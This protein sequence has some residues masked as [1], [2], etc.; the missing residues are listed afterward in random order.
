MGGQSG[1]G[2]YCCEGSM[3]MVSVT[4]NASLKPVSSVWGLG[5][6]NTRT[7]DAERRTQNKNKTCLTAEYAERRR[8]IPGSWILDLGTLLTA[9][10]LVF[11]AGCSGQQ[12]RER[13]TVSSIPSE[14]RQDTTVSGTIKVKGEVKVFPKATLTVKPGTRFLFEPF[15][16]DGDGVNDSRLLIEGVLIAR[17]DPDAPIYFSSAAA[18]PEPGD[19]LELR[20]DHSEGSVLEYCILEHSRYGLHVHFS[21]GYVMNSVFRDNIDGTRFGNSS[22]EFIFN[23]I[24]GNEG[25]GIN[26]R[27]SRI[28]IADNRIEGNGHG[29]FLFEKTGGSLIG[30]NLF[31]G[32]ERSDIR[33]GDFYEGEPPATMGNRREDGASL[34]VEGFQGEIDPGKAIEGFPWSQWKPGPMVLQYSAREIWRKR[35]GSFID[36][37]PVFKE[38][39]H[40]KI[41]VLSW[42][43]GLLVLDTATGAEIARVSIPDVTDASPEFMDGVLYFPSWDRTVRAVDMDSGEILAAVEWAPSMADDHRQASPVGS[44]M[45]QIYMG[46][47]NGDFRELD[48]AK[49]EW[50]WSIPLDGPV[51]GAAALAQDFLWVGT[52]AGSLFKVSREGEVLKHLDLGSP[53]RAAPAFIGEDGLV[54][55]TWDGVLYRLKEGLISWRRKLS[56][57][58]TYGAPVVLQHH[59][60]QIMV[61]DGSGTVS[62]FTGNGALMWNL[63]MGSAVHVVSGPAYGLMLAGTE[64]NGVGIFT[65]TGRFLGTLESQ[66]AVHGMAF[67]GRENDALAVYGARD[68]VVRAYSLTLSKKRWEIPE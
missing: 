8:G 49:M 52:D 3:V 39:D 50:T 20:M 12:I 15:D 48:T 34:Q 67:L 56:G 14:I 68:G 7:Q 18:Q 58:G 30:F 45:G 21:S 60:D 33:F 36:A 10:L 59:H 9:F 57:S 31:A 13:E 64:S 32:N 37:A 65:S 43:E 16:P 24:R 35:V 63:D 29:I 40:E 11:T 25:K 46:L 6:G 28:N 4:L 38:P 51:R 5:S 42:E 53:V 47:W 41:A 62:S 23:L 17:G 61:G 66:G 19:W 2:G 26:L 1:G 55:V 54:V 44:W 27:D 22:F